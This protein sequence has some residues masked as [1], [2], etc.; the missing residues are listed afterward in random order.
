MTHF[1]SEFYF[2]QAVNDANEALHKLPKLDGL[3]YPDV[4]IPKAMFT[5]IYQGSLGVGGR[6]DSYYE[7][8]LKQWIQLGKPHNHP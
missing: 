3:V 6:V 8:L 1:E 2:A 4:S 7:Y 5:N